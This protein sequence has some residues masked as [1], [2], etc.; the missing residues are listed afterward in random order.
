MRSEMI[1]AIATS[2]DRGGFPRPMGLR[3]ARARVQ[4][5]D[6]YGRLVY[7]AV[8]RIVRDRAVAEDL[9]LET[10]LHVWSRAQDID[11]LKGAV[12]PWLLAAARNRG[13]SY[14]RSRQGRDSGPALF[15]E[16]VDAQ[17]CAGLHARLSFAEQVRRAGQAL[18]M[19]EANQRQVIE[20][21]YLD[22]LTLSEIAARLGQAPGRVKTW[23]H[24]AF[25]A[26]RKT[27]EAEVPE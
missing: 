23:L 3:D 20:L 21:A 1:P 14:L 7:A 8:L 12:G 19:L 9:V 6:R 27:M 16:D 22:G 24:V 15:G 13:M 2:D 18:A 25:A 10:F 17:P 5:Y 11:R 26:L 4:L